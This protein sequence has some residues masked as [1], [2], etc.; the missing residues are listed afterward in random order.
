MKHDL[1]IDELSKLIIIK[2][3]QAGELQNSGGDD[4]ESNK[5]RARVL[6]EQ[7]LEL[8]ASIATLERAQKETV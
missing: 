5:V 3:R 2:E 1:A 6:G 7:T 4:E 8:R